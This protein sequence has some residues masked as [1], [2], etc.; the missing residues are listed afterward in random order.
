M[1]ILAEGLLKSSKG[2][3]PFSKPEHCPAVVT[4]Y[5]YQVEVAPAACSAATCVA[6]TFAADPLAVF[7]RSSSDPEW[8]QRVN[9]APG[10]SAA[11]AAI[12]ASGI[13]PFVA[14]VGALGLPEGLVD[15]ADPQANMST[16]NPRAMATRNASLFGNR[17][18]NLDIWTP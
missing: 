10:N 13:G 12:W 3:A 17:A 2:V 4:R 5:W 15:A 6:N 7:A 8:E 18:E 9:E 16:A 14:D 1:V 11:W